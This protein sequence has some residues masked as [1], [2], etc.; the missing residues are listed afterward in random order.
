MWHPQRGVP[1]GVHRGNYQTTERVNHCRGEG[2]DGCH[3]NTT[4]TFSRQVCNENFREIY[5]HR[6]VKFY[7]LYNYVHD[8]I[9][10]H[11]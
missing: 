3:G 4:D 10:R 6:G 2:I 1:A 11:V 9:A 7:R 8:E 5:R